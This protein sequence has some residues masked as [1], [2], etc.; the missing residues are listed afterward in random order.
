M[1]RDERKDKQDRSL[2][3][4]MK[5]F[6]MAGKRSEEGMDKLVDEEILWNVWKVWKTVVLLMTILLTP[7]SKHECVIISDVA[8]ESPPKSAQPIR[9]TNEY[10]KISQ[11]IR[12]QK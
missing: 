2:G 3:K 12:V 5:A 10:L 7:Q 1:E 9:K 11:P 6:L 8:L 4:R